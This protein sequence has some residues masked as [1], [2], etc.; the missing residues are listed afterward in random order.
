MYH[1]LTS[2]FRTLNS[3]LAAGI[4]ILAFS[5]L[6]YALSFN[7]KDRV[8]RSFAL[9]LTCVVIV[10]V[11][12]ALSS[13]SKDPDQLEFWLRFQ[14]V[15][16]I[17]LP[18]NY[19]LFSD[20]LLSTTGRP[21]RG[22]RVML[23]RLVALVSV[24]FLVLLVMNKLVGALVTP[25][26]PAPHLERT[27]ITWVFGLF[28]AAS[29]ILSWIN[30]WRAYKRTVTGTSRRR[31]SYLII[32]S[33]APAL[34]SYPY[35]LFGST[36]AQLAPLLFWIAVTLGNVLTTI[37]LVVMAYSVAFF[38]VPWPDRVVKRRLF[39]WLLRG[40][41]T[42][43]TVLVLTTT[44]RRISSHYNIDLSAVIP[45]FMVASILLLEHMITLVSPGL[46]RWL[47][48]GKDS[49]DLDRLQIL[50]ERLLTS[51]DLQQFLESIL[52]A[53]CDRLQVQKAFIATLNAQRVETLVM[54]GGEDPLMEK[55]FPVDLI[56]GASNNGDDLTL[57]AWG[58]R[59]LVPLFDRRGYQSDLIGL[60]SVEQKGGH[61]LDN[62]QKAALE[63]LA[64]RAGIA[65]GDRFLQEEAFR[66]L[67]QLTPQIEMIQRL[68]A[69]SR[70]DGTQILTSP[71]FPIDE[72]GLSPLV[73]DA[74]THY[75]G[76]P[77]LTSSP[78]LNLQVV[79][80]IAEE[81]KESSINALRMI[82]KK[83][84]E[85]VRPDGERR[86]TAEWVLYNIL[87]LKFMEG[88]KVRDIATRLAVSEAD[89]YRKQRIAIEAV[90]KAIMDMEKEAIQEADHN[91]TL[92]PEN[93]HNFKENAQ[94][95]RFSG[96]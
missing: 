92:K 61:E 35:L 44:I 95:G 5:L 50:D 81:Q 13:V 47:F 15:G 24:G 30:F 52:A 45:V 16:I 8:A 12:E 32:G 40:P 49:P 65:I 36:F 25:A 56:K 73:K 26:T 87:E 10:F 89:L 96:K 46:E 94:E 29:M 21:S 93:H 2:F 41:I 4:A 79:K 74:L 88:Y 66:S 72:D 86:F 18:V 59:W 55:D 91:V 23:I 38:G 71:D 77:K 3:F 33:L 64:Y 75:W 43:S 9:I 80:R 82:L 60:L 70:Y 20:A 85:R 48:Y 67:D 58:E 83:A 42:A 62:E 78:L 14:W 34:G 1:I 76:G 17:F 54:F 51:G 19:L 7:L 53:V 31:M 84:I 6:L 57:F 63:L 69:A 11:G 37:L 90:R 68:R 22:R 27:W 39:K 28:Y